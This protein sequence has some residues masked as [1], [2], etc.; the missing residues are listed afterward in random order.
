LLNL[1]EE[2]CTKLLIVRRGEF[3]AYGTIDEIVQAHPELSGQSLE[4]VFIALTSDAKG[5]A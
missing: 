4:D 1:V 3:V 5:A 2:L